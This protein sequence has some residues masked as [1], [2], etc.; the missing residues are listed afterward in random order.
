MR[1]YIFGDSDLAA[2]RLGVLADAFAASSR[3]FMTWAAE[4]GV[5][6][7]VDLGCGPG[8]TTH[9]LAD[10][11]ECQKAVGLDNSE[12]FIALAEIT[13]TDKVAFRLHDVTTVPFPVGP[14][15]LIYSRFLL[16]HQTD[17]EKLLTKWATQLCPGGLLLLE[18]VDA[19]RTENPTFVEYI[20]AVE[21]TLADGG[22][23]LYVGRALDTIQK[24][25]GL[26]RC[27]SR[28]VRAPVT[29]QTAAKMFSMNIQSWKHN[30]FVRKNYSSASIQQLEESL[31]RLAIKPSS[32][33]GV[34]W[35]L[36]QLVYKREN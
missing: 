2:R 25:N 16:T 30:A 17:A 4:S 35:F 33:K 7:A 10:A 1:K 32:N 18:E 3:A 22:G 14:C 29:S 19:I 9:L 27:E 8:Y 5:R 24:A 13:V 11:L 15:D 28:I 20:Q 36:R 26:L 23:N 6:L 31:V 21:Q 12:H 34:E